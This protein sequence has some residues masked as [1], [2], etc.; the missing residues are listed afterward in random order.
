MK[1]KVLSVV[2]L[3][4]MC[5]SL[6]AG[7]TTAEQKKEPYKA[8]LPTAIVDTDIFVTPVEGIA[9]DFIRGMDISSVLAEEA[10]G[11]KY[12]NEKGEEEDLF[13]ILADAGINYI[14]VRVWNDPFDE[15]GKGYGGGNCDAKAAA[16]IGKRAAE[17]GMKLLVDFHYSDFWAD[18]AKQMAPK[19]WE[20]MLMIHEKEKA[21]YDYTKESLKTIIDAGANVGMVQ[22]GNEINN[23]L[24]GEKRTDNI[25]KFLSSASKAVRETSADIKVTV[26]YTNID[27]VGDMVKKAQQLVDYNVDY[28]VFGI[29]Y[30]PYWHGTLANLE[31]VL[32]DVKTKFNKETCIVETGYMYTG[33]DG[34]MFGNNVSEGDALDAY[35]ASVQG[36]ASCIRDIC[37]VASKSGALGVF[38]WEGAWVPVGSDYEANKQLWEEHGS[39]WAS[40][41]SVDYDPDDAGEYYGGCS[42]DNQAM[43]DFSGKALSS[44]S[45]WKYLKY[46]AKAASVDVI[47]VI[48]PSVEVECRHELKMP[49]TVEA[50]YNDP[51]CTTPLKVTWDA[52]AV[53]AIDLNVPGKYVINGTTEKNTTVTCNVKVFNQNFLKDWSF[54][55]K[56]ADAWKFTYL[57][58]A[59]TGVNF[60]KKAADCITGEIECHFWNTAEQEFTVEQTIKDVP[61]GKYAATSYIQGGDVGDA[62]VKFYVIV[63]DKKYESEP[64]ALTG[65]LVWQNPLLK[66]IVIDGTTDVTV[67]MY[68]K[69]AADGWGTMDDF[70]FYSQE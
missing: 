59:T 52:A 36:Q 29:S 60:E 12:Y 62:V 19:A 26:H 64:L 33:E 55:E 9:D 66:D 43:F 17:Y 1:K 10:S 44:L 31:E 27:K 65:W 56:N 3:A 18:P 40:S 34:D 13:K 7:C 22:I 37:A 41:Y 49:E 35:P 14:R 63:G 23:G 20:T 50:V 11:V 45:V 67:G 15:N 51:T 58:G 5:V 25:C 48:N 2:L 68:V 32:T 21:I 42:W 39:G 24:A 70:E 53:A 4:A 46:G 47:S 30:Y 57:N 6:L 54:E 8:T 16:E 69:C 28:D 38:Y 61:A